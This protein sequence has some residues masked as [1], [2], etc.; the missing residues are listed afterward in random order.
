MLMCYPVT[1]RA[2]CVLLCRF[3]FARTDDADLQVYTQLPSVRDGE[4]HAFA[5]GEYK[6]AQ[7]DVDMVLFFDGKSLR[8]ERLAA[9]VTGLQ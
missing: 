7:Q 9:S 2:F 6:D 1:L 8:M 5:N 3:S 4:L